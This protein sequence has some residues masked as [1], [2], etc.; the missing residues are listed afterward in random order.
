MRTDGRG[1]QNLKSTIQN[2]LGRERMQQTP[3]FP[4]PVALLG[5]STFHSLPLYS[6][7]PAPGFRVYEVFGRENEW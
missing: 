2:Q 5:L 7:A 1:I 4:V 3:N 6:L